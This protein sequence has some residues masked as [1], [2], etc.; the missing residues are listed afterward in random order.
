MKNQPVCKT[1]KD[2][3]KHWYL[4]GKYHRED[5]PAVEWADGAKFWYLN[6]ELHREDGPAVEYADDNKRWYLNGNLH[7]EDGPAV[8]RANGDKCWY[9]NSKQVTKDYFIRW[10]IA[11]RCKPH[12]SPEVLKRLTAAGYFDHEEP[13]S[14]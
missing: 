7:R 5:G 9:I 8:E 11:Q 10:Q 1:G 4:N 14:L 13:T 6:G 12:C 2:G 3:T